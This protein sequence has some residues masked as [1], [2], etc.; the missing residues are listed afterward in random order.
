MFSDRLYY[1]TPRKAAFTATVLSCNPAA[2][3]YRVTLDRIGFYPGGGGQP[4]DTGTVNGIPAVGTDEDAPAVLLPSPLE[5]GTQ[6]ACEIDLAR[7]LAFMRRHSGEHIV[8]GLLHTLTGGDNVG[9][10]MNDSLV[11]LDW[12]LPLDEKMLR[13]VERRVNEIVMADVP[14]TSAVYPSAPESVA[15]RAKRAIDGEV[16]LVTVEGVDVC[17]CCGLHVGRTGEIGL[18]RLAD[19]IRWKGGSRVTML[20]GMDALEDAVTIAGQ[21]REVARLVSAKPYET[22]EGVRA[23][24]AA[25]EALRA[26][27]TALKKRLMA[28]RVAELSSV[29]GRLVLFEDAMEPDDLRRM[30]LALSGTRVDLVAVFSG[31]DAGVYRYAIARANGDVREFTKALNTRFSGRG[32]GS[33]VLTQGSLTGER[34]AI[35]EAVKTA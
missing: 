17:A 16:R 26:G 22:G 13:D 33:A 29:P 2:D 11:T 15:Y 20:A 18:I 8:S 24:L 32:G 35:E 1:D 12:S 34:R 31:D 28:Y 3:A 10:H 25:A 14:I 9:F 5:P 23:A 4:A 19:A 30:A 7:R 27:N 6:V 21:N